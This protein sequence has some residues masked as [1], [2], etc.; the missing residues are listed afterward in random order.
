[1]SDVLL[2]YLKM[3]ERYP[4][5]I[6]LNKAQQKSRHIDLMK[7]TKQEYQSLPDINE[8]K[9]FM[10]ANKSLKY[11][12][13]FFLKVVIPCVLKDMDDGKIESLCFLFECNGMDYYKG[14]ATDYVYLL[15]V[16]TNYKYDDTLEFADMVLLHEP[17]NDIVLNYKYMKLL[18]YLDYYLHEVPLAVL[19][20][21]E[22]VP[23]MK[24]KL[25]ELELVSKKLDKYD[26]R[27]IQQWSDI[28]TAWEQYLGNEGSY[29]SFED[30]LI[31]HKV[32]YIY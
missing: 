17:D 7:W 25:N 2:D 32:T 16:G 4:A 11:E 18:Q 14:T 26:G 21:K 3:Y 22:T 6:S 27:L 20:D 31:K 29:N 1:M 19:C 8:I 30:Y 28:F 12:P 15:C 24:K 5:D 13:P 10:S 9:S 23:F